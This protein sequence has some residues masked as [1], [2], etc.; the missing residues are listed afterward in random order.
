MHFSLLAAC[1]YAHAIVCM[2]DMLGMR[3]VNA[4]LFD[5]L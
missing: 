5:H 1:C 2:F 4:P 3:S